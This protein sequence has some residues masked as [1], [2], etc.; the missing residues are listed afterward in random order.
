[1]PAGHEP[2]APKAASTAGGFPVFDSARQRRAQAR[3]AAGYDTHA[4]LPREI[5]GRMA[6]RLDYVTISPSRVLD[7]G[8]GSG[9]DLA[10]LQAR[11][12]AAT[13]IGIDAC[14]EMLMAGRSPQDAS[15]TARLARFSKGLLGKSSTGAAFRAAASAEAL[16]LPSRSLGLVWSNLMLADL[17]DPRPA[18]AE[19]ARVLEVGGLWMFA[20]LGPD[21]L[22][23]LRAAGVAAGAPAL[24]HPFIDMHDLGDLLVHAG[25]ADPVMDME[26]LTLTYADLGALLAE[27]KGLGSTCALAGRRRGLTT[28]SH[29]RQVEAAYRLLPDGRLP[30]TVEV[31]YGHAWKAERK[32]AD[33]GRAIVRFMERPAGGSLK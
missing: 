19:T 29:W 16:P 8:C 23:E 18:I 5:A 7:L 28:A 31:V 30:A 3:A 1:M 13:V 14:P 11:Y 33:D 4:F 9:A 2:H 12:P 21:T 24:T 26:T 22:R 17:A 20:T 10:M 15:L 6:E 27:L 32:T 25:F